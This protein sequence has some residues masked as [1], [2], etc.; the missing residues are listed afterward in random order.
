MKEQAA[1]DAAQRPRL[2]RHQRGQIFVGVQRLLSYSPIHGYGLMGTL[3]ALHPVETPQLVLRELVKTDSA[4]LSVFM[5]QA[6][7]QK[8]IS[9]RLKDETMVQDFVSRQM[10]AQR[11]GRRQVYHLAAEERFSTDVVG[12][13][14]IIKHGDGSHEIGWGVHPA[15]WS[16][17]LGT[18]I[19]R[20]L[21]GVAFERLR[22]K[23]V[24]CKVMAENKASARLARKIGL[25]TL[26]TIAAYPLGQGRTTQVTMFGLKTQEYFELPY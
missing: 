4:Q 19:G 26:E 5:T 25:R 2:A 14:F 3:I 1:K 20:A 13:G 23:S 15:M 11:D 12:D 10:A 18:E 21:L 6:K 16:M 24:W 17:G 9:H 22:A 7:Y 8:H